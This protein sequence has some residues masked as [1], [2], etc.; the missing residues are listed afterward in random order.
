MKDTGHKINMQK[1]VVCFY[2]LTIN[3]LKK[4][5]KK[6]PFTRALKRIK[7]VGINLTT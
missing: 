3:K 6:I 4:E 1:L 5:S 7:Y 2:M